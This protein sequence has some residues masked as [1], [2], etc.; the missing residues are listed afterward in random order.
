MA[1]YECKLEWLSSYPIVLESIG[2]VFSGRIC[3]S[4][5]LYPIFLIVYIS[6]LNFI[7]WTIK[8]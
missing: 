7:L 6:L 5:V 3:S 8:D 1:R 2:G 4:E